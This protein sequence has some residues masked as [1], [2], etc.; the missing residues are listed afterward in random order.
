MKQVILDSY[1]GEDTRITFI[2]WY[3]DDKITMYD[4]QARTA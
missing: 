3:Y 2:G 4:P 1:I